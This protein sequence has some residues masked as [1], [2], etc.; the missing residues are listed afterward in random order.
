MV[1]EVADARVDGLPCR[2]APPVAYF[3]IDQRPEPVQ[4][5]EVPPR[6]PFT[7]LPAEIRQSLYQLAPALP[8]TEI[9][10]LNLQFDD[11][12]ST[13]ALLARLTSIFGALTLAL[14]S[15]WILRFVLVPRGKKNV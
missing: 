12:L 15:P 9:V 7:S 4:S 10:P 11:G 3:P 5:I 13:E 14:G 1:G 8:V 6:G 2:S